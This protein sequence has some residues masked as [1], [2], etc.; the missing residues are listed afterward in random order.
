MNKRGQFFI[1]AALIIVIIIIG[2]GTSYVSFKAP[3]ED[4]RVYD[5]SSEINFESSKV[6]DNGIISGSNTEVYNNLK[7]L[8]D[9]YAL[10]NPDSDFVIYYGDEN[11]IKA[12]SYEGKEQGTVSLSL[13]TE[14]IETNIQPRTIQEDTVTPSCPPL[15]EE[16]EKQ[17]DVILE[18]TLSK[19]EEYKYKF[20][21]KKGQNFFILMKKEKGDERIVVSNE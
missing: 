17:I 21:L 1:I 14:S 19:N 11:E 4:I 10:L 5:L 15:M 2:L 12:R 7:Q 3:E 18:N 8:S 16:C 6:I 20:N 13:G 9:S